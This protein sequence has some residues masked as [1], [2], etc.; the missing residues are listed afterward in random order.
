MRINSKDMDKILSYTPTVSPMRLDIM[1]NERYRQ[2][3]KI[4]CNIGQVYPYEALRNFV[5]R[6]FPSLKRVDFDLLPT[7]RK[8]FK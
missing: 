2:T 1:V 5:R 4:D 3:I 8:V 6:R 7:D